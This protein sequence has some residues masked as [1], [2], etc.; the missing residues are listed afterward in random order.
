MNEYPGIGVNMFIGAPKKK[1]IQPEQ[2]W[3]GE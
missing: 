3:R 1:V 2:K